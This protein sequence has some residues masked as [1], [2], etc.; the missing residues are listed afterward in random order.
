[1][2]LRAS[3]RASGTVMVSVSMLFG[4]EEFETALS[5]A[6]PFGMTGAKRHHLAH[7]PGH[8]RSEI[9]RTAPASLQG[10]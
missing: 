8:G 2:S 4:S 7:D 6:G 1:M 5:V 10:S 9:S 3:A